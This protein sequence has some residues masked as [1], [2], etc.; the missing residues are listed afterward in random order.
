MAIL[1]VCRF[2]KGYLYFSRLFSEGQ[3]LVPLSH[4]KDFKLDG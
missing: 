1:S 3:A 4:D 2:A